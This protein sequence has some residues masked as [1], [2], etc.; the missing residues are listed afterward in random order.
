MAGLIR[1]PLAWMVLAEVIVVSALVLVA[2]NVVTA[3]TRTA[4]QVQPVDT[5]GSPSPSPDMLQPSSPAHVAPL[6]GLNLDTAFWR[7]RLEDM[8]RDQVFFEQLEWRVVHSA[9][10]AM[11]RYL[12]TVVVPAVQRAEHSR[13]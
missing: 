11:Q 6:P 13:S 5:S 8:N 9:V 2:W 1:K 7:Q 10:N 3:P 12:E 4:V